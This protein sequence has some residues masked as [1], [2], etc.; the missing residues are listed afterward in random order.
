[1]KDFVDCV[2]VDISD[3]LFT[4]FRTWP[5]IGDTGEMEQLRIQEIGLPFWEDIDYEFHLMVTEPETVVGDWILAGASSI[6]VHLEAVN[7]MEAIS[8]MCKASEVSLGL[9]LKP[10]TDSALIKQY[11]EVIDCI[12]CMGSNDLGHHD[13]VLDESTFA[14]IEKLRELY[15]NKDIAIDIGVT[16][17]TA[18]QF[19]DAGV[20]KLIS[21][22]AIFESGDRKEVIEYF[23]SL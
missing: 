19:V 15:P 23:R 12:Q 1:V 16:E 2:Q 3:G 6:V 20:T 8:K 13:A 18:P 10:S 17:L 21:G 11:A 5:Y 9:A 4:K 22:G 7:D 14:R